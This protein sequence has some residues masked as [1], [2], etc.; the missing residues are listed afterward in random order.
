MGLNHSPKIVTNGLVLCLDAANVKSYPGSGSTWYDLSGKN[1]H[2]SLSG[3]PISNR[4]TNYT[5]AEGATITFN[6]NDFTFDFE[7]TI[8]IAL[9]PTENDAT[10]RNPYNQAYGGGGTWTHEPDGSIS[11]YYGTAG[12]NN[13]PY[14]GVG[15]G[16]T[17]AQNEWAIVTTSR[18]TTNNF[19]RWY[20]NGIL[21]TN[22]TSAYAQVVTGTQN[23][24]IGQ[25]YASPYIGN[26][27]YVALYNRALTTTEIEQNFNALRGRFGL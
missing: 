8:M 14:V 13:I 18:S 12:V 3:I 25:G 11:Y 4:T 22:T 24:T 2:A 17:V 15:S 21:Y 7:Q 19:M 1:N 16:L 26:I 10:R 23:I 6:S 27:D 5:G 20:K 9:R